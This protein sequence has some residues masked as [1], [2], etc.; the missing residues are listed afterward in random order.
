MSIEV[1]W[2]NAE[3]TIVC[4][5]FRPGWTWDEFYESTAIRT[6][7]LMKEVSHTVSIISDFRDSGSMPMGGAV[8]RANS[9]MKNL[10]ANWGVLVVVSDSSFIRA[11]VNVF[12]RVYVGE[13]GRKT[14][15]ATTMDEAYRIIN[16]E[17]SAPQLGI[18]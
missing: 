15:A 14:F 1:Q 16:G 13:M 2:D 11:L 4:Q 12:K 6:P 10:P 3:K 8:S 5:I 18:N 7:T 17:T 9:A